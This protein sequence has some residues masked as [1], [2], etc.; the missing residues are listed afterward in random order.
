MHEMHVAQLQAT[1]QNQELMGQM[2]VSQE[3]LIGRVESLSAA[4]SGYTAPPLAVQACFPYH[5]AQW[6]QMDA[7]ET[8]RRMDA[9]PLNPP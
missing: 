6:Y 8:Q 1:Q 7:E 4:I 2:V 3:A 9:S 5:Q